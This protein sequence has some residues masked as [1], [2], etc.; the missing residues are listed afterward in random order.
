MAKR[1]MKHRAQSRPLAPQQAA[2]ATGY[3]TFTRTETAS[4]S[5]GVNLAEEYHY[6]IGDLKRIGVLA[7]G[8]FALM[9]VLAVLAPYVI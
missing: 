6:V 9:V 8:L 2:T 3:T 5:R 4:P 7:A 1:K